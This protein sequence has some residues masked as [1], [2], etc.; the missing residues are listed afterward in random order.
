MFAI[1]PNLQP[2][3]LDQIGYFVN[4]GDNISSRRARGQRR[5][6]AVA[7]Q[8][9]PLSLRRS[10]P[11]RLELSSRPRR[12]QAPAPRIPSTCKLG[13]WS[14]GLVAIALSMLL[15]IAG[16][17]GSP[18]VLG[19][20]RRANSEHRVERGRPRRSALPPARRPRSSRPALLEA[21]TCGTPPRRDHWPN[22]AVAPAW[23]PRWPGT[24]MAHGC[25]MATMAATSICL[26]STQG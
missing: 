21:S 9:Q 26:M 2:R 16:I 3:Q 17:R 22:F 18:A 15:W 5:V 11:G 24:R 13:L 12:V 20:A 6:G 8:P 23:Q 14:L 25:S 1:N 4:G 19:V 10:G 7:G